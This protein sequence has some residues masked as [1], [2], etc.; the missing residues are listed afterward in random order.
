MQSYKGKVRSTGNNFPTFDEF[1]TNIYDCPVN[2]AKMFFSLHLRGC[3]SQITA[4]TTKQ[5][6]NC[7]VHMAQTKLDICGMP[8][9]KEF[10]HVLATHRQGLTE[11]IS[12]KLIP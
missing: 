3:S 8:L 6:N 7:I 10:S 9:G 1:S 5:A 12:G 4:V 2:E 11:I